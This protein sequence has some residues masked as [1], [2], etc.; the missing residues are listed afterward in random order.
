MENCL[1]GL[2][3]CEVIAIIVEKEVEV[4]IGSKNKEYYESLGYEIPKHY[5]A[6]RNRTSVKKGNKNNCIG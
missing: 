1:H 2:T 5:D 6:R 3:K 4:T